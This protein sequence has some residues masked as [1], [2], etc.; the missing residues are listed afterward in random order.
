MSEQ[1]LKLHVPREA[2]PGVERAVRRGK[3]TQIRLRALYFDTS[4][5]ELVRARIAL[6]LRLEGTQW[7]QTLKMPGEH[8]LSRIEFNQDRPDATL[9]LSIYAG[10]HAGEVLGHLK[11]P[12]E[13]CYETDVQRLLRETRIK[14]GVVEVA[15]DRGWIKA[16]AL[17]LP[18][19]EIEFELKRGRLAAV[20]EMGRQW[21]RKFGLVLDFRS[22]A[23]RGDRLAQLAQ[24]L[25][26]LESR[27]ILD[28]NA[29]QQQA[30]ERAQKVA[31]F[32]SP[33][34]TQ[35]VS[36][37]KSARQQDAAQVLAVVTAECLEQIARNAAFLCEVD[38]AGICKTGN[39]EHVHQLRVGIRRLRSAWSF[40]DGIAALPSLAVRDATKVYF[41]Q[42]GG[43]RDSDVL[44]DFILPLL[45]KAGQPPLEW[46]QSA[47]SE[48]GF[49]TVR[50]AAF[51]G[52]LLDLLELSVS[53][54][55]PSAFVVTPPETPAEPATGEHV[56]F[57][58]PRAAK[59]P[60]LKPLLIKKLNA[61]HRK[62]LKEGLVFRAL[63][64][65]RQ[66]ALRKKCKRLRYAMQFCE[67]LLL[68]QQL[69]PYRKQLA[70]TQDILGEMNDLFVAG[71]L[72]AE[73]IKTQPH[74]WFA[75]G[76]IAARMEVLSLEAAAAFEVL[77][78]TKPPWAKPAKR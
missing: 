30:L 67:S 57:A 65:E 52:W 49:E 28:D 31:E 41:S 7:V 69:Q 37:P 40:F 14:G 44:R 17:Q 50:S 71:P 58:F 4:T 43:A 34:G 18:V 60:P 46:S 47:S 21:Q 13:I 23:E 45:D 51:Q 33:R 19:S 8:S 39:P 56:N 74:A 3:P 53:P 6:R 76:W 62:I 9:D 1:E 70:A 35:A 12:L 20:F 42:L 48:A 55:E 68:P 63:E 16:S 25:D 5:R 11:Q 61:W 78:A 15:F 38:T 2:Q 26:A 75:S 32:W 73:L 27:E 72:F 54:A 29:R 64:S 36:M 22:K 77:A 59:E 66:H 10:T 24:T